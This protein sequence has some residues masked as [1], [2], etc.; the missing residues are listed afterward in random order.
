[1][2]KARHVHARETKKKKNDCIL[3]PSSS[4]RRA[5]DFLVPFPEYTT[6]IAFFFNRILKRRF[7]FLCDFCKTQP[8]IV[9]HILSQVETP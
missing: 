1:M 3:S 5:M 2:K 7:I 6:T 9:V 4:P 8:Q